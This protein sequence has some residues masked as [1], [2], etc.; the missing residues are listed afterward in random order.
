MRLHMLDGFGK[1]YK[2]ESLV[3]KDP[4]LWSLTAKK[5]CNYACDYQEHQDT[6][7]L[8]YERYSSR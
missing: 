7:T 4:K 2:M 5:M 6:K 3:E 8:S 1:I